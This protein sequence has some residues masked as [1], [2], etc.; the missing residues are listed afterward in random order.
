MYWLTEH[1]STAAADR[2]SAR[3]HKALPQLE[4]RPFSCGLAYENR[5]FSE[6]VRHLLFKVRKG[7]AYRALFIVQG[8]LVK[9]LCI[10]AP[11][12]KPVKPKDIKA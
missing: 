3:F 9:I 7:R 8:D 12:E 2:L 1:H 5:Y 6:E 10:R 4:S 11:G